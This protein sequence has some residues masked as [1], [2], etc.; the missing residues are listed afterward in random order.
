MKR[1]MKVGEEYQYSE[2]FIEAV[3]RALPEEVPIAAY[4]IE[5][6]PIQ[7]EA[8]YRRLR[9]EILFNFSEVAVIAQKLNISID[10]IINVWNIDKV[11]FDTN[12]IDHVSPANN[13][14][15][16]L[17]NHLNLLERL[18]F[19]DKVSFKAAFNTIPYS[20]FLS[21]ESIAKFQLYK[22][23][24]NVCNE[25]MKPYSDFKV[26]REIK[27]IQ[28]KCRHTMTQLDSFEYI[29][30]KRLFM[31]LAEDIAQFHEMKLLTDAEKRKL[32]DEVLLM[33][34]DIEE[35]SMTGLSKA[36]K[37]PT[38]IF[39]SNI[40]FDTSYILYQS[41]SYEVAHFRLFTITGIRSDNSKI[42][43]KQKNW[44]ESLKKN[45]T[46]ITLSNAIFRNNFFKIQR[47]FIEKALK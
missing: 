15:G 29:L 42:C 16:L 10:N 13:Y 5:N 33:L 45:S 12:L 6:L 43:E 39:I 37:K 7:R 26:S 4:L 31:Y 46:K 35:V 20:F 19:L 24:F 34:S 27:T 38:S 23:S 1:N 17:E 25:H 3:K 30:D 40:H 36:T 22:Y 18:N 32:K 41:E 21:Y 9:G 11:S 8:V 14:T 2:R 47:T 44:L 28:E